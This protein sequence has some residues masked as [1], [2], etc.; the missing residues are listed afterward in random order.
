MLFDQAGLGRGKVGGRGI[1]KSAAVRGLE[2]GT[3]FGEVYLSYYLPGTPSEMYSFGTE[4]WFAILGIPFAALIASYT[5]VPIFYK[6]ELTS[7]YEV[8]YRNK[9]CNL[10]IGIAGK[11]RQ[12]IS[13]ITSFGIFTTR[14]AVPGKEIRQQVSSVPGH[15]ALPPPR[16]VVPRRGH[17]RPCLGH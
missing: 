2:R 11:L 8:L 9:K 4:W 17:L 3:S 6:L 14:A 15:R 7:I 1:G 16:D 12:Q 5:F 13:W 10:R